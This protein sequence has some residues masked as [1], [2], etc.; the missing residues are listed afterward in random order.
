MCQIVTPKIRN[1]LLLLFFHSAQRVILKETRLLV[2]KTLSKSPNT[3]S[4][5]RL[6]N[7]LSVSV[8]FFFFFFSWEECCWS[9]EVNS[10]TLCL[11][12]KLALRSGSGTPLCPF[13]G[14]FP[15]G[16]GRRCFYEWWQASGGKALQQQ[17][18]LSWRKCLKAGSQDF[19]QNKWLADA[20]PPPQ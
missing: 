13:P 14:L 12:E 1:V 16:T 6:R 10:S 20:L 4:S 11:S 3:G 15:L 9:R 7:K 17:H 18:K 2:S 19:S 8:Q 5:N